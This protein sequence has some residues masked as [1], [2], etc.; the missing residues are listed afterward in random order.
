M[1]TNSPS[2]METLMATSTADESGHAAGQSMQA[3]ADE[4]VEGYPFSR[5]KLRRSGRRW[6]AFRDASIPNRIRGILP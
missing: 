4:Y 2:I 6:I 3:F 1:R 5:E